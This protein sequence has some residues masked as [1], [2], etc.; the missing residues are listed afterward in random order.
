[1]PVHDVEVQIVCA[2][3]DDLV[4]LLGQPGE[5]TGQHG[6]PDHGRAVVVAARHACYIHCIEL[7]LCKEK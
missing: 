1:M 3:L 4:C 6:G 5:V 7:R 2:G